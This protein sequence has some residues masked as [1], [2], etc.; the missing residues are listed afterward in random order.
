MQACRKSFIAWKLLK[1]LPAAFPIVLKAGKLMQMTINSDMCQVLQNN[2]IHISV[3]IPGKQLKHIYIV[4]NIELLSAELPRC[5][6]YLHYDIHYQF[7]LVCT[8]AMHISR[9]F[10]KDTFNKK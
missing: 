1:T 4:P 9:N 7:G 6:N 5:E 3:V 8:K 10:V 2:P